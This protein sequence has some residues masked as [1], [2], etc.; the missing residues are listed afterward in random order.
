[1]NEIFKPQELSTH[2]IFLSDCLLF[3]IAV[4]ELVDVSQFNI[5][6]QSDGIG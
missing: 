1:M 5:S 3:P 6:W 2:T 4:W